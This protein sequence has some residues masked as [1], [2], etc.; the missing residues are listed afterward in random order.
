MNVVADMLNSF[1]QHNVNIILKKHGLK[2]QDVT[3]HFSH[4]EQ[5]LFLSVS[6]N[7]TGMCISG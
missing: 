1:K 4:V 2:C 6:A 3:A 5:R 7:K